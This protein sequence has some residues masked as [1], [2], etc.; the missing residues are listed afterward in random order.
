MLVTG[1]ELTEELEKRLNS[2]SALSERCRLALGTLRSPLFLPDKVNTVLFWLLDTLDKKYKNR[3]AGG[4]TEDLVL[5]RTL[6]SCLQHL[7]VSG[8]NIDVTKV[9]VPETLTNLL[10]VSELS[11][12]CVASCVSSLI[13]LS[14]PAQPS[15]PLWAGILSSLLASSPDSLCSILGVFDTLQV[16]EAP[17]QVKLVTSFCR[18]H[19][20]HP[21]PTLQKITR[22]LLFPTADPYINLFLQLSSCDGKYN[23]GH[24]VSLL[25]SLL[26][27]STFS[28]RLLLEACPAQPAWLKPK[29]LSLLLSCSGC[30]GIINP[31]SVLG[32]KILAETT[33]PRDIGGLFRAALPID[34]SQEMRPG[35]HVG[36]YLTDVVQHLAD[37]PGMSADLRDVVTSLHDHHPQ[38]LEPLVPLLTVKL[39]EDHRE[40]D[41]GLF[42]QLLDVQIK[43][44]QVPKMI[45]KLF[46]Q[47]RSSQLT[48]LFWSPLD[49]QL[50]GSTIASLPKVQSLEI[51]KSLNY[52]L[53]TDVI[54]SKDEAQ[55]DSTSNILGPV[56]ST[57][58]A[59][60]ELADQNLPSTLVP[61]IQDLMESTLL[62]L[63]KL[64]TKTNLSSSQKLLMIQVTSAAVELGCLLAHYRKLEIFE[65]V[66][67]FGQRIVKMF[68]NEKE[69]LKDPRTGSFVVRFSSAEN[70][71]RISPELSHGLV[72]EI[73]FNP[74]LI[75]SLSQNA[76]LKLV[77]EKLPSECSLFENP[78][79]CAGIIY[80]SLTK[81]NKEELLYIPEFEY[82]RSSESYSQLESFLGKKICSALSSALHSSPT[83]HSLPGEYLLKLRQLPIEHLPPVLKL[84]ASL[85]FVSLL[86]CAERGERKQELELDCC[87]CLETTD[88]FRFVD[89]GMFLNKLLSLRVS[90][91]L[92]DVVCKSAGRFTKSINDVRK[93]FEEL[94]KNDDELKG[95]LCLLKVLQKTMNEDN[96]GSDRKT[97]SIA[98]A[99]RISKFVL[100][101]FKKRNI[102]NEDELDTFC[103]LSGCLLNIYAK[104]ELGKVSILLATMIDLSLN[105]KC[106]SWKSL[107]QSVCANHFLLDSSILP[108]NW[109]VTFLKLLIDEE[110]SFNYDLLK[111]L[112]KTASLEEMKSMMQF[113]IEKDFI[114]PQLWTQII[115]AD[116]DES[117]GA[118][119]KDGVEAAVGK[120]CSNLHNSDP[121]QI[122]DFLRAIFSSSPPCV[123]QHVEISCL[124]SLHLLPP[125]LAPQSLS[126]LSVFISQRSSL[127]TRIIPLIFSIIRGC[128]TSPVNVETLQSL[129][130]VLGL[131]S[132]QKTDYAP[133][134]CYLL[135]DLLHM[136]H[137]LQPRDRGLITNSIYPLLDLVEKHNLAFLSSSLPPATTELFKHL[138]AQYNTT[139]RFKGKI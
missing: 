57:V 31:D 45:S 115:L 121:G 50:L 53:S 124:G 64:E 131:F 79:F 125:S 76:F 87:R 113:L 73:E 95:S 111:S 8:H 9:G 118:L 24:V 30:P 35:Y 56:F 19:S 109:R 102:E 136:L 112:F 16:L 33:I 134:I 78:Q 17:E 7:E 65:K 93:Y 110:D 88:L 41:Y 70:F 133:V 63:E 101:K 89:A 137:S 107:L 81:L 32:A 48:D 90:I 96:V 18:V 4:N 10:A 34:L 68:V 98:L 38:L 46:L 49:L 25:V 61:R 123:S 22:Q 67:T 138:L 55:V 83:R 127:S 72:S 119:K 40:G 69:H 129:Q 28:P 36:Q 130:K 13:V 114:S 103:H 23:P 66:S 54:A 128:M 106:K 37:Q 108:L 75:N 117:C 62:Q 44:R 105:E 1:D 26:T 15:H 27:S 43:L 84:S 139:Q 92:L 86:L 42:S 100:M 80:K 2:N 5:W 132:R 135:A 104:N 20:T 122:F 51:W 99:D 94:E 29:L 77:E 21:H 3:L 85:V 59:N 52:H 58:L 11:E 39:L 91:D 120:I 12:P 97:A 47:M 74:D 82:W 126:C 60:S 116:V 71:S 6:L 14:L